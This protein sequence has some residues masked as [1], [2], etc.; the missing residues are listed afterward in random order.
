M[1]ADAGSVRSSARSSPSATVTG[2]DVKT[3]VAGSVI[4]TV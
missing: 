2:I 1:C 3:A 4:Q